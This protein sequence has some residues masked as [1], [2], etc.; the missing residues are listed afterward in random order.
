[1]MGPLLGSQPFKHYSLPEATS[2]LLSQSQVGHSPCPLAHSPVSRSEA[3][4]YCVSST[5]LTPICYEAIFTFLLTS[6]LYQEN[7]ILV[8]YNSTFSSRLL[9]GIL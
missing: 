1:M 6:N 9:Y 3:T 4:R 2:A 7:V 5:H 8:S